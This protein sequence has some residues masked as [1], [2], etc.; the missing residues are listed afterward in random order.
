MASGDTELWALCRASAH[1]LIYVKLSIFQTCCQCDEPVTD[2]DKEAEE[3][4]RVWMW[5]LC[6]FYECQCKACC[7]ALY[8]SYRNVALYVLFH[9]TQLLAARQSVSVVG[10]SL[11]EI[12][13]IYNCMIICYGM[14]FIYTSHTELGSPPARN[15]YVTYSC[16]Y[17]W[18]G[19]QSGSCHGDD[20][21]RFFKKLYLTKGDSVIK[22][23][24]YHGK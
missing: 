16:N 15:I 14:S 6:C 8:P 24:W 3:L 21:L 12:L 7:T 10:S 20:N 2:N 13:L 22:S 1:K 11:T 9:S 18:Y 23:R 4:M 19:M 5:I 17:Y